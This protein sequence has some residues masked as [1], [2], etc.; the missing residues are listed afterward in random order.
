MNYIGNY[1]RY[2]DD[3]TLFVCTCMNG[4][5]IREEISVVFIPDA[6]GTLDAGPFQIGDLR[7]DLDDIVIA[8]RQKV[9][10][11]N[12]GQRQIESHL[13]DFRV[14]DAQITEEFS[15]PDLEPAD[16]IGMIDNAHRIG[17]RIDD[18]DSNG[19]SFQ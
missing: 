4:I 3:F 13:F 8:R 11:E 9:M 1:P 2:P 18:P 7:L 17:I 6:I 14:H 16:I 15:A 5:A 12:L 19:S 10:T